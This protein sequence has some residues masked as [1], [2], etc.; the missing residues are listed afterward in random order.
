MG[1]RVGRKA[2]RDG[3]E[4]EECEKDEA[5]ALGKRDSEA[6]LLKKRERRKDSRGRRSIETACGVNA[7]GF[8]AM[9]MALQRTPGGFKMS[10]RRA[11][12]KR[13]S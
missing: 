6:A 1:K 11:L 10:L 5:R 13:M 2:V 4:M 8:R 3:G 7:R 12:G 9:P